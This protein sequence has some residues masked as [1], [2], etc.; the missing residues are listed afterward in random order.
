MNFSF[1]ITEYGIITINRGLTLC[2]LFDKKTSKFEP[3]IIFLTAFHYHLKI[4]RH[5]CKNVIQLNYEIFKFNNLSAPADL[6][7]LK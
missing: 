5:P 4:L 1:F 2:S 7:P 3:A 6:L